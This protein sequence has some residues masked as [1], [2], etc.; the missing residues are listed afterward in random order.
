MHK[1]IL[2]LESRAIYDFYGPKY[3]SEIYDKKKI[4]LEKLLTDNSVF[5]K[6][7]EDIYDHFFV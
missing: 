5:Q 7:M 2:N 4:I 3:K 6:K 1:N